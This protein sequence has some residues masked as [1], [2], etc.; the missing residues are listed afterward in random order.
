MGVIETPL[1]IAVSELKVTGEH[2][3]EK[4]NGDILVLE[5][6][7][8]LVTISHTGLVLDMNGKQIGKAKP[9]PAKG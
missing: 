8:V 4:K 7:H 6:E 1:G 2:L 3:W 9:L 5:G